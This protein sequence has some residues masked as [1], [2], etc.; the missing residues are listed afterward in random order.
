MTNSSGVNTQDFNRQRKT[1]VNKRGVLL[2][3]VFCLLLAL[4]PFVILHIIV[5]FAEFMK[6]QNKTG[7]M[8]ALRFLY[9][10]FFFFGIW[11]VFHLF[12]DFFLWANIGL[13]FVC[14]FLG[15]LFFRILFLSYVNRVLDEG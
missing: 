11:L 5:V 3:F 2:K 15:R 4:L 6:Y 13:C 8:L 7:K 14:Y 12:A 10:L 1:P 9:W